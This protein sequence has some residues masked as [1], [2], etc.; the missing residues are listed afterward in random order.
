M[1]HRDA[2]GVEW[3]RPHTLSWRSELRLMPNSCLGT[4]VIVLLR[5]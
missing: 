2:A 3:V 1:A 5:S 4:L